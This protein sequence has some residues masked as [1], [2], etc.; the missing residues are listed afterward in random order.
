MKRKNRL[1]AL[2]LT[3]ASL[4]LLFASC[5]E[6]GIGSESAV[7][8]DPYVARSV[9]LGLA[10]NEMLMDIVE[11]EGGFRATVGV[12][13]EGIEEEYGSLGTP[14]LTEYRYYD[15]NYAELSNKRMDTVAPYEVAASADPTQNLVLGGIPYERTKGIYEGVQYVIYRDGQPLD[16]LVI[17]GYMMDVSG[18]PYTHYGAMGYVMQ[19]EDTVYAGIRYANDDSGIWYVYIDGY[20]MEIPYGDIEDPWYTLC[21]LMGIN[22]KPYALVKVEE[23]SHEGPVVNTIRET[24]RLVPLTPQSYELPLEGVDIAALP[25]GGAFGDGEYGYFFCETELWRT[26]GIN[27]EKLVDLLPQGVSII[28]ELRAVRA[29]SDGRILVVAD[30]GLIELTEAA[31]ARKLGLDADVARKPVLTI[32][33]VNDYG[34]IYDISL[35]A[36]KYPS[37][38]VTLAVKKYR[39]KTNLN[40]A[41]LSGEVDIVATHDMFLLRN[42][43]KQEVLAPLDEVTPELFE[44]GVLIENIVDATRIDGICYYLPRNFNVYGQISEVRY[45]EDGQ[46]FETRKEY[47]DFLTKE[48]LGYLKPTLKQDALMEFTQD[49][50]EWIDWET[51]TAHFDGDEF[52]A[53]LEF[54][55]KAA[56]QEEQDAYYMTPF[57]MYATSIYLQNTLP[58]NHFDNVEDAR[59]YLAGFPEEQ[60]ESKEAWVYYPLPSAVYNGY[61]IGGFPFYAIVN[62]E[63]KLEAA[64]DFIR[65]HFIE[66]VEEFTEETWRTQIPINRDEADRYLKQNVDGVEHLEIDP[67]MSANLQNKI[68]ELNETMDLLG[69]E[70]QYYRTWAMIR[71]ADHFRYFRNVVYDVM[72]E[73]AT[74]YF[75]GDIT[76]D[77][78]ADYIQNRVSIFLAEQS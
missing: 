51:N 49:L 14:Y 62:K 39:D 19:Y 36:A 22:G 65:W 25:T 53:V 13:H 47:L 59:E 45:M 17:V 73:E 29:M 11:V 12:T 69:G 52:K 38:E 70:E 77:Q 4:L 27:C 61:A 16:G 28:S 3:L 57:E 66:D 41:I 60:R 34:S 54:C 46:T 7:N 55:N 10:D 8:R 74:R 20:F 26:D 48:E 23:R 32:G 6:R 44:E 56:T 72:H 68:E 43:A 67:A 50:D 71:Q 64:A 40:L 15:A 75:N 18:G 78:A 31:V 33:V 9:D 76:L 21:G 24:G 1:I 5:I 63:E 42:Y 2:L 58:S 30:G 37:K 35:A